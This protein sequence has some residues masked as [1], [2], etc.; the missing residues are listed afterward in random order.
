MFYVYADG[1]LI[2]H[3]LEETLIITAPRLTLE[4]GKAG[5]FQFGLPPN[6]KFYDSL[7][8]LKTKI[9]VEIDDTEVFRG[10]ILSETKDSY[11]IRTIYCEGDLA[12]LVDSV[13]KGEKYTGTTHELFRKIIAAHNARVEEDKRFEVGTIGIEDREI[14][15]T[16]QSSEIT[17]E[18]SDSFDYK[19]IAI[20]SITNEWKTTYDYIETCLINYCGGYLR[21]RRE[22]DKTYLDLATDFGNSADQQIE[23]GINMLELTEEVSAEDLFTVLI[24]LGD[25]NL[26]IEA[27][28]NGSD[29]LVDTE[30]AAIYGRI[31]KTHVFENVNQ[32]STLLENGQRFLTNHANVPATITIRA[33]DMHLLDDQIPVIKIGDSVPV[34]SKPH[35]ITRN[36]NCT[37]IEYDFENLGN[38]TFTFGTLQ[39]SLTER[40]RKD[41]SQSEEKAASGGASGG[42]AAGSAAEEAAKQIGDK[43][44]DAWINVD[45][46]TGHIDLGTLY[47]EYK[48]AKVVLENSCGINIDAPDG[49]INICDLKI[50]YDEQQNEILKQGARIDLVNDET[51]ASI[52]LAVSRITTL[53]GLESGH[54]ASIVLR[55]DD[56]ES[57]IELKADKVTL[58]AMNVNLNAH[59]SR[60]QGLEDDL[61]E[62]KVDITTLY[63]TTNEADERLTAN[64]T[65]ITSLSNSTESKI[66]ALASRTTATEEKT[67]SLEIRVSDTESEINLKADKTTIN[68][69]ITKINGRLETAEADIKTLKSEYAEIDTLISNK[70]D[71][72]IADVSWLKSKLVTVTS[73]IA[74]NAVYGATIKMGGVLVATQD[75]VNTQLANYASSSHSHA[76]SA[77][78]GK[79]SSFTP[80]K[81]RHSFSAS[82]TI[83]N[84]HTHK[85][86]IDGTY[87]TSLGVST[88]S[89]HSVSI[90]GT[91][92]Y[93]PT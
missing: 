92:G 73:L 63:E 16:G 14:I 58:D 12:Y 28:N 33:V 29:E 43:I 51:H 78:T 91:T 42:G 74:S 4:M 88:N 26:T 70:I 46:E 48:N 69:K 27:V 10:R 50:K 1:K 9:T 61:K 17:D 13:Q 37:K 68:S 47:T 3:P 15:L 21:T 40:Y 64:E 75:W 34:K 87:Y 67:A 86:K 57:S 53:E 23:F 90:S 62:S 38:C 66:T 56:L 55:V 41:K 25:D 85:V 39:Q 44:Y 59:T 80:T 89:S 32:P 65:K 11:N 71:A 22:G 18:D 45:E 19:Q 30:M 7:Q 35:N 8:K 20:N 82:Q 93:Y 60:L 36:L 54:Y 72:K 77:I 84:G 2:Y 5:S 6:N 24:P 49:N 81:H 83:A 31:V 79:P 76:W 52:N